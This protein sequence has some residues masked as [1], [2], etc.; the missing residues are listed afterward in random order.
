METAYAQS[1]VTKLPGSLVG[2]FFWKFT[3][4]NDGNIAFHV[5][6]NKQ[7]VLNRHKK[8]AKDL[9]YDFHSLV[10][11]KQVHGKKV[12]KINERHSFNTPPACDAMITDI[13]NKPLMVM[14][15]DCT[16]ILLYDK[17]QKAVAAIHAGRG[18]AFLNILSKVAEA[19]KKNYGTDPKDLTVKMGPSIKNCCY[20]VNDAIKKEA[21]GLGYGFAV[22]QREGKVFLDVNVILHK[23]LQDLTI[24][25]ENIE[26]DGR[27]TCC[28][29]EALFSY[30]GDSQ[31]TGRFAGIAMIAYDL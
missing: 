15:A 27:C 12:I 3:D 14:V 4:R 19:M 2:E 5:G 17:K 13:P 6:D 9:K 28:K 1:A 11:M 23:Q 20:E 22:S 31:K 8:L 21:E 30:R 26:E 29:K 16:P 10:W 18:G 7:D 25:K 24:K